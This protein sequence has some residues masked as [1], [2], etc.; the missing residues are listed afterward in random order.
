MNIIVIKET[1]KTEAWDGN[2]CIE[3]ATP[4]TEKN[5]DIKKTSQ[6]FFS[7]NFGRNKDSSIIIN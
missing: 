6:G 3:N 1:E 5:K 4:M 7:A 2:N